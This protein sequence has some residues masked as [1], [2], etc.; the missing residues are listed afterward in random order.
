MLIDQFMWGYQLHF[1]SKY[2]HQA[3]KVLQILGVKSENVE[4]FLVGVR[5]PDAHNCHVVCIEPEKGKWQLA[6]FDGLLDSIESE[7]AVHPERNMRY[8][9]VATTQDKPENVRR[10]STRTA[11][12][13]CL[14]DYDS[15]HRVTSFVGSPAPIG[16]YYVVPVLQLPVTLFARFQPL[17][18]PGSDGLFTGDDSLIHAAIDQVLDEAYNELLQPDPGRSLLRSRSATEVSREAAKRFMRTPA[19]ALNSKYLGGSELFD[20]FNLIAS[21]MYEGARGSGRLLLTNLDSDSV[22]LTLRFVEP[23]PFSEPRWVRKVLEM[24][25]GNTSLVADCDKIFG[26]GCLSQGIDPWE[27]QDVFQIE[28]EGYYQWSLS[29]GEEV[30]LTSTNGIPSLPTESFPEARLCDTYQRLFPEAKPADLQRFIE[31]LNV[32]IHAGHGSTLIVALDAE[33][34]VERL[35]RQGTRVTPTLLTPQLFTLVSSIDG[36]IIVDPHGICYAIGVILDGA[37]RPECTPAR[38]SR[39]NSAVRYVHSSS[40]P[41]LAVVVSDDRIVDL[42]Q[43]LRPRIKS[44]NIS[45]YVAELESANKDNYHRSINW[46]DG[47]RFYLDEEMC[48]RVNTALDRIQKE[49][50]EVGEIQII[51]PEFTPDSD[52]DPSYLYKN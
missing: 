40:N 47:H 11:V 26:L 24:A 2:E 21:L 5:R 6:H 48:N 22:D 37:A 19:L 13:K 14:I 38:G 12:Q 46:L 18:I 44:L 4:C 9:D 29:C 39:Y 50:R 49:P 3:N 31:L 1:R 34:E 17:S 43:L 42:I 10:D 41:R 25:S 45:E 51:W 28:F 36:A 7:I 20:R 35:E 30:L 27:R 8:G 23:V 52:F 33:Q 15:S 32:A 16:D